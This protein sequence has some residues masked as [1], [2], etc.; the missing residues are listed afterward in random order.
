MSELTFGSTPHKP[1]LPYGSGAVKAVETRALPVKAAQPIY[2]YTAL[3]NALWVGES[4]LKQGKRTVISCKI[5][6][7]HMKT[8]HLIPLALVLA[9]CSSAPHSRALSVEQATALARRLANEQAQAQYHCQPFRGGPTA[10]L[11]QGHWVWRDLKGQGQL[12]VEGSVDFAAD[13]ASPTVRVMLL[14]SRTRLQ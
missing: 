11:V 8:R 3:A 12:D 7:E 13:G 5:P 9:G 14:D 2:R 6:H 4:A 1:I 10:E